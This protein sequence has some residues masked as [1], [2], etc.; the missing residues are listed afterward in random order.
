M[1]RE[2]I[3]DLTLYIAGAWHQNLKEGHLIGALLFYLFYHASQLGSK[4]AQLDLC[5]V[6]IM[7]KGALYV[8]ILDVQIWAFHSKEYDHFIFYCC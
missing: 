2:I 5:T 7:H 4:C 6:C 8:D 3:T 1:F